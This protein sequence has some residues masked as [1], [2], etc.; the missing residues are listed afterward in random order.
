VLHLQTWGSVAEYTRGA[1]GPR[2]GQDL[3]PAKEVQGGEWL[4][5]QS[6]LSISN[7]RSPDIGHP[8]SLVS[9]MVIDSGTHHC[10]SL[11]LVE[12]QAGELLAPH[13]RGPFGGFEEVLVCVVGL[14][15][16]CLGILFLS[17]MA[18]CLKQ[19]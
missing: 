16:F 13:C 15:L 14:C 5:C 3:D 18:E 17:L 11:P 4:E 8:G 10:L 19:A 9:T 1:C 7:P 12:T 6:S 2:W